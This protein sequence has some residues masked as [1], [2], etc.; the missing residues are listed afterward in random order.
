VPISQCPWPRPK[1]FASINNFGFGGT[2]A[3]VV[4]ER[5]P[6]LKKH[7]AAGT[8]SPEGTFQARK[9]FVLSANDKTA[10]ETLM[11]NLGIYLEQRPEI[12]QNDLMSNVA[13]TLGQRR[14]LMQWRMAISSATSFDLI[15]TLNAGKLSPSRETDPPRIG[16]IFTGQGAQWNA[17]GR[18]LYEQYTIFAAT[19]DACDKWLASFGASFSLVGMFHRSCQIMSRELM[20]SS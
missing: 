19:I 12:F 9:L 15:Q 3:H 5:A 16:F 7:E 17:M 8:D 2:N 13:Y 14:S 1:P 10:L 6:F 18:E 20:I 4:L 11:K